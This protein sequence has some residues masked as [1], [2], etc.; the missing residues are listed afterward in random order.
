MFLEYVWLRRNIALAVLLLFITSTACE[1]E[2]YEV[3]PYAY[4][5]VYLQVSTDLAN[6]GQGIAA[7]IP[8]SDMGVNGI[9]LYRD[10]DDIY[11]NPQFF[12]YD[13]TCTYQ[14]VDENCKVS[15]EEFE[16]V[17]TC[18]CCSSSFIV[19]ADAVPTSGSK[20]RLPLK[21]YNTTLTNAG[22]T[23]HIYN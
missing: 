16:T 22:Q 11:G 13:G 6:W 12:A 3:V 18:P 23:L 1:R 21:R 19:S 7:Y 15:L 20:A 5:N 4:V 9:I 10:M 17:A 2:K 14:P 8:R